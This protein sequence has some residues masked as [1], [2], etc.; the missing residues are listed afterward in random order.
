VDREISPGLTLGVAYVGSRGTRLPSTLR[1][2][3]ALDPDLLSMGPLLYDEFQPGQPELHGVRLPYEG[4]VEQMQSCVPSVA[5]A[6]LAY[7]KYCFNL[8]GLNENHGKSTYHSLQAKLEK[9]LTGGTFF[10]VSYT[11]SSN[12]RSIQLAARL[13]F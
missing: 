13:Q 12:P 4:W 3:N 1:P 9:R 8:E 5:Q 6:L 2:L 10:L 7:L 11:L